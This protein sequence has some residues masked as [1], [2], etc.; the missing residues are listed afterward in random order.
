MYIYIM[1][2]SNICIVINNLEMYN[3][4][5]SLSICELLNAPNI[6]YNIYFRFLIT[7]RKMQ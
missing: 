3:M 1:Y 4:F 6:N 2:P 5:I 7:E